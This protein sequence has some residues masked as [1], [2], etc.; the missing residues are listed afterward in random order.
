MFFITSAYSWYGGAYS[1]PESLFMGARKGMVTPA[2]EFPPFAPLAEAFRRRL[3]RVE[4]ELFQGG[5]KVAVPLD[6]ADVDAVARVARHVE[7]SVDVEVTVDEHRE[8][9]P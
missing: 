1:L 2:V 9:A 6:L 4:P 5:V 3:L 8:R 7:E